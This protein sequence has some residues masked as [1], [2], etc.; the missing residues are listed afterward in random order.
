M[1]EL[2][3]YVVVPATVGGLVGLAVMLLTTKESYTDK[4]GYASAVRRAAPSVVNIYS[5]SASHRICEN[6]RY[7]DWCRDNARMQN[8]LGS[9][10]VVRDDGY[11]LTNNHVIQGA[12]EILVAFTNG[13]ATTA[14]IVG[15]DPDTDLAVIKVQASGL[16]VIPIAERT[17][18][19]GDV[20]LAIGNP[21]GIGQTVSQGIIS[22]KGRAAITPMPHDDF[23]QTDAA[24]NPG[25]SGGAL[26][27]SSG[28]LIGINTMM[29]SQSG[30]SEGIGFAI[31]TTLALAILDE[32]VATGRVT[33]GWLGI[34]LAETVQFDSG[35]GVLVTRVLNRGPAFDAGLRT[36]DVI[37]EINDRRVDSSSVVSR[38]IAET[39]PGTTVTL[40]IMRDGRFM[41]LTANSGRRPTF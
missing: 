22:A 11:I 27:D 4:P 37:V 2:L 5:T 1:R 8:A 19:V 3:R 25:N 35:L 38:T 7:R 41:S 29:Y 6:P 23:I 18:E 24:I 13:Q 36:G 30:G 32:I 31:P 20:A 12:S 21:F 40:D 28:A 17:T 15:T 33:R 34:E 16:P 10:V 14:Q 9:G 26:I 39:N